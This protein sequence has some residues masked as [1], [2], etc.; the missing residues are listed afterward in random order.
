[1]PEFC[2][3]SPTTGHGLPDFNGRRRRHCPLH[4][5]GRCRNGRPRT[6][7]LSK[8][9]VFVLRESSIHFDIVL[10]VEGDSSRRDISNRQWQTRFHDR[11][12]CCDDAVSD[13]GSASLAAENCTVLTAE[14]R[15]ESWRTRRLHS[16]VISCAD[17]KP[18][19][20]D[21]QRLAFVEQAAVYTAAVESNESSGGID[22]RQ[23]PDISQL[24]C[25]RVRYPPPVFSA[26]A[27]RIPKICKREEIRGLARSQG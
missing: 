8:I 26:N 22:K 17:G 20:L 21:K 15:G 11:L 10:L 12:C 3:D 4:L 18:R 19:N 27:S 14:N 1:V 9:R 13:F 23:R 5:V 2:L 7:Q 24:H 16:L 25:T 6:W